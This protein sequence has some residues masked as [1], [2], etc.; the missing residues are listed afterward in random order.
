MLEGRYKRGDAVLGKAACFGLNCSQQKVVYIDR[1]IDVD[2]LNINDLLH[3]F[4][5][6]P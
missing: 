2:W 6:L 5:I 3:K 1:F 4:R